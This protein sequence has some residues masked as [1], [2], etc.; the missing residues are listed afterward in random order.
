MYRPALKPTG[1]SFFTYRSRHRILICLAIFV[2]A[3]ISLNF[4]GS[5]R[6]SFAWLNSNYDLPKHLDR[7]N[8]GVIIAVLSTD[9]EAGMLRR[10]YGRRW[11]RRYQNSLTIPEQGENTSTTVPFNWV[12]VVD[13]S[14]QTHWEGDVLYLN[15]PGGYKHLGEKMRRLFVHLSQT[16]TSMEFLIKTDDDVVLCLNR[17]AK[18]VSEVPKE[19]RRRI[20]GGTLWNAELPQDPKHKFYDP[21][22]VQDTRG[23]VIKTH[24]YGVGA[25]YMVGWD[26]VRFIGRNAEEL[27]VYEIEDLMV[28]TWLYGLDR[29][30]ADYD[31]DFNCGCFKYAEKFL[32]KA[33][34]AK[35]I[36]DKSIWGERSVWWHDCKTRFQLDGC[37]AVFKDSAC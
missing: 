4:F 3:V 30:W 9:D 1:Y 20:Y 33:N 34:E 36:R 37:H 27:K 8:G 17:L 24:P 16:F 22:F 35:G 14:K 31:G 18:A 2:S 13:T 23:T 32:G 26:L 21:L 11:W 10:E 15:T 7:S 5:T 29:Y 19:K 28:G 12:F 6:K 25:A